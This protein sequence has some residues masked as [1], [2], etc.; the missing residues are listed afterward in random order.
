M[1]VD[2]R[3]LAGPGFDA[4]R[5]ALCELRIKVFRAWPYLYDGDLAYEAGYLARFKD[6]D[7]AFMAAA[8]DGD[9]IVGAAT[10]APMAGEAAAF[11]EPFE[12]AGFDVSRIFYFAESLLL[13]QYRGRGLGHQFFDA[14]EAHARSFGNYT[15]AVFCGVVRPDDHPA[16]PHD[17]RRLDGFWRKRGFD[18]LDGVTTSYSWK[19]VGETTETS[20]PM[21]FWMKQL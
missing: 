2:V 12:R 16:R 5:P 3:P 11:R 9:A 18:K 4:A 20:K 15:H 17:Y 8:F 13:P 7:R 21:Q 6:A 19:D 14:R 10:A 1:S